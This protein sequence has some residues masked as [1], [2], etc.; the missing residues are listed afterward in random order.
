LWQFYFQPPAGDSMTFA[1]ATTRRLHRVTIRR[2]RIETM[3]WDGVQ[4]ATEVWRRT[5]EDGA[6]ESTLWLAP[7][8]QWVPLKMRAEHT[9][10]GT[11]EAVLDAIRVDEPIA[12]APAQQASQ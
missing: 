9:T 12:Q 6:T 4:V 3:Q 8:L 1:V 10:R 11:V 5:S 7:T 2:E